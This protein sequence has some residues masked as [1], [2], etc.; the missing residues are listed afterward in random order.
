MN[1]KVCGR[2]RLWP[3]LCNCISTFI[4]IVYV[5]VVGDD[6]AIPAASGSNE[7]T[8]GKTQQRT[9]GFLVEV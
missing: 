2:K 3:V 6:G 8:H 4:D 7:K 9:A 5:N 1:W